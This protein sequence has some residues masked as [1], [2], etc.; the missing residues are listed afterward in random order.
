VQP[1][2]SGTSFLWTRRVANLMVSC[3]W[4]LR[5]KKRIQG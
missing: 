2:S 5:E 1:A 4:F 3:V